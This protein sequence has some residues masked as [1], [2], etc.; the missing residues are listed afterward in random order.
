MARNNGLDGRGI[1]GGNK[2]GAGPVGKCVCP[3]CGYRKSHVRGKR[4]MD[5]SCPKCGTKMVR[6]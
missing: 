1:G 4:C 2:A 3:K 6:E 5:I